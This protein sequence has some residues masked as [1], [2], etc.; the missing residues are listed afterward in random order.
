MPAQQRLED[1]PEVLF[2]VDDQDAAHCEK[3]ASPSPPA[4][5]P[6]R[7]ALPSTAPARVQSD[8]VPAR[9]DPSSP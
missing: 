3:N 5:Q 8:S 7:S 4:P 6:I 2:V 1:E 9:L